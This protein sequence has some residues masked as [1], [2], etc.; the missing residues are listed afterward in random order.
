MAHQN[1]W[2]F[3]D[4]PNLASFT[5]VNVLERGEPILLVTHD[6]SDGA[7][8]FLCG[9]TNAVEDARVI[10]L[11]CALR[12]DP[13]LADLA[14]LPRGWQAWRENVQSPWRRGPLPPDSEDEVE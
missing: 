11:D 3:D 1:E 8:Q 2:P 7:W 6:E 10:G 13:G 14:D 9:K 12:L 4:P 5:T